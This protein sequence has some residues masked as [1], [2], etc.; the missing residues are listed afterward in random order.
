MDLGHSVVE[1]FVFVFLAFFKNL[2]FQCR[3]QCLKERRT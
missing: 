2:S 1:D 3:V